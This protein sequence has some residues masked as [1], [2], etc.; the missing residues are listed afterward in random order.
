MIES[1]GSLILRG[2]WGLGLGLGLAHGADVR[3]EGRA[4]KKIQDSIISTCYSV[5][6]QLYKHACLTQIIVAMTDSVFIQL[7]LKLCSRVWIVHVDFHDGM[8]SPV[9][10]AT[11][12]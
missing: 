7:N 2:L 10:K 4:L 5:G 6:N 11:T 3:I 9:C 1:Y 12:L 8:S